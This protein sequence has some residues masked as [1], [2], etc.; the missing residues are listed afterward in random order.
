MCCPRPVV[1]THSKTKVFKHSS[2]FPF[3]SR[4]TCAHLLARSSAGPRRRW[5]KSALYCITC[6]PWSCAQPYLYKYSKEYS[7]ASLV[8]FR[9]LQTRDFTT[10]K[11]ILNISANRKQ[12]EKNRTCFCEVCS[13]IDVFTGCYT[14]MEKCNQEYLTCLLHSS[15]GQLIQLLQVSACLIM[16]SSYTLHMTL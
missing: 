4:L 16:A 11:T 2:I 12:L 9:H 15:K 5:C 7:E 8:N 1:A 14:N 3:S 13:K 6:W 10:T